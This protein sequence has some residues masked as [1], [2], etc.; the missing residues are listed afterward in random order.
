[1]SNER[2]SLTSEIKPCLSFH[3]S[4]PIRINHNEHMTPVTLMS[5]ITHSEVTTIFKYVV[6]L[7]AAMSCQTEIFYSPNTGKYR[8]WLKL[9][10]STATIHV[11]EIPFRLDIRSICNI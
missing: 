9:E 2:Q 10:Y 5:V 7:V 6:L 11:I 4:S 8:T 1:M 3:E